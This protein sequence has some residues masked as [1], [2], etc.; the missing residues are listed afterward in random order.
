M[1]AADSSRA[2]VLRAALIGVPALASALAVGHLAGALIAPGASPYVAVANSVIDLSPPWLVEFA[3]EAFGTANK[4]VL[5]AGMAVVLLAL[6]VFAGWLALRR[7]VL[8]LVVVGMLGVAGL[9]AVLT[10]PDVGPFAVLAPL[11]SVLAG[12]IVFAWLHA[13]ATA[14]EPVA[15]PDEGASAGRA[16]G[17]PVLR[18]AGAEPVTRPRHEVGAEE[19][20]AAQQASDE[21][22]AGG[23]RQPEQ[24]A[25]EPG[26][27][28]AG[29]PQ[30]SDS[31]VDRRRLLVGSAGALVG[32]GLVGAAGQWLAGPDAEASRRAVAPFV[33][34]KRPPAP[35]GGADFASW[36][37]PAFIT[38]NENF[39]TVHTAFVLPRLRAEDWRLR[40]HGMVDRPVTLTY[41]QLRSRPLVERTITMACVSNPVG[42]DLV[43]TANFIGVDLA[44][45]LTEVGVQAGAEQLFSTS[46][47]G[48][49]AGTPIDAVLEPGR[50]MLAIGMNGEPLP[51][52]HGFPVRMVVAGLYG[53]V[54]A[55]KWLV[56]LEVT[57]WRA[58]TPYWVPRGWAREGPVKTQ[59]RI[60]K[61][62]ADGGSVR[63]A[64]TAWAPHIGIDKVEVQIDDGPWQAAELATEVSKDTWRMWRLSAR[65]D[66][67]EHTV[68]CRATDRSGYTQTSK[69]APPAPD[70]T[71][72]WHEVSF[73]A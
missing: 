55:T 19:A 13:R 43:S 31:G 3:K 58:R 51:V 71:T 12:S 66:P 60:D 18:D 48:F 30:R 64:G 65:V 21:P 54:S 6:A 50:A 52:A 14:G 29:Q 70:G 10:R 46:E 7:L 11:V 59:S 16:P 33:G 67:G 26:K 20:E 56:D 41:Q 44:E 35:P 8:G 15:G 69:V 62:T 53:F 45:L 73:S 47:D 22:D 61:V 49:T 23:A 57:T 4:V 38:P 2:S 34:I 72:G 25:A 1:T 68:R 9:A 5:F 42:G 63:V 36:G 28:T 37:T 17:A 32:A 40:I 39:Y 24:P 27:V